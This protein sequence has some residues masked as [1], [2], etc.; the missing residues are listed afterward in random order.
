MDVTTDWSD[1]PRYE[2][3]RCLIEIERCEAQVSGVAKALTTLGA[4][5]GDMLDDVVGNI[6]SSRLRLR[7]CLTI[8]GGED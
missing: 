6:Y 4:N 7:A 3:Q 5:G 2:A 1:N 8:I